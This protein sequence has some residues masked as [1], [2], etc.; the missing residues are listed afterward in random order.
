MGVNSIPGSGELSSCPKNLE[1]L[2][3]VVSKLTAIETLSRT[4]R[5][6]R[7]NGNEAGA[8]ELDQELD[9]MF[10]EKERAVGR[11]QEHVREHGC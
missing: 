6:A 3:D 11:W 10:G 9:L 7:Q 5:E 4:Q 2:N 1:L 8:Q